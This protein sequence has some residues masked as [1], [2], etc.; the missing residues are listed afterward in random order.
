MVYELYHSNLDEAFLYLSVS[1]APECKSPPHETTTT[2]QTDSA[3]TAIAGSS[4]D[5]TSTT[6]SGQA[7]DVSTNA[8]Y[9][10][11]ITIHQSCFFSKITNVYGF[12]VASECEGPLQQT[13]TTEQTDSST[14]ATAGGNGQTNTTSTLDGATMSTGTRFDNS[15]T[16]RFESKT[17]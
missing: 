5:I 13:T 9:S 7:S 1:A 4:T 12:S 16:F 2:S 11:I 6:S 14:T 17:S 3:T 15:P 10:E 8:R